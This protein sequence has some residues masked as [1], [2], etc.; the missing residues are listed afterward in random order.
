MLQIYVTSQEIRHI[1]GSVIHGLPQ[2]TQTLIFIVT[3]FPF[4]HKINKKMNP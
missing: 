2:Q 1:N 3:Y 4:I